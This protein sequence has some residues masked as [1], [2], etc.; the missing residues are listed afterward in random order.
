[1]GVMWPR[2]GFL[3]AYVLLVSFTN[4]SKVNDFLVSLLVTS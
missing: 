1:M 3:L 4:A 2:I